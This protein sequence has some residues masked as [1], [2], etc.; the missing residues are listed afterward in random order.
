M[1]KKK[2][3]LIILLLV[4][5][6]V[7]VMAV[8]L[9]G[10]NKNNQVESTTSVVGF[11]SGLESIELFQVFEVENW[12]TSSFQVNETNATI[13]SKYGS[14]SNVYVVENPVKQYDFTGKMIYVRDGN[15]KMNIYQVECIIGKYDEPVMKVREF[16]EKFEMEA[17]SYVRAGENVTETETLDGNIINVE[18]LEMPLEEAVYTKGNYTKTYVVKD[19]LPGYDDESL[20]SRSRKYEIN[21]YKAGNGNVI[22]EL[23]YIFE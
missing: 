5:L 23:V 17:S 13:A 19:E 14:V 22:G 18:E 7:L 3:F 10:K 20:D 12:S 21:F 9:K 11:N 16:M 2:L 6:F 4:I 15:N 8:I 1:E